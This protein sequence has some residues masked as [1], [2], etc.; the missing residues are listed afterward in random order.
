MKLQDHNNGEIHRTNNGK[1]EFVLNNKLEARFD[2]IHALIKAYPKQR[3][4]KVSNDAEVKTNGQQD[5]NREQAKP[6][7]TTRQKTKK[8]KVSKKS[9]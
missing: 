3:T 8:A 4:D 5:S 7:K 6:K 9:S 2:N 1:Y